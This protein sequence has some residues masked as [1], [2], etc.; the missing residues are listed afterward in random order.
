MEKKKQKQLAAC[1][2][3]YFIKHLKDCWAKTFNSDVLSMC[4]LKILLGS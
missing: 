2:L 1:G 3:N 4:D